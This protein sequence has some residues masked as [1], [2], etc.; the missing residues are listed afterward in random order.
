MVSGEYSRINLYSL[1]NRKGAKHSDDNCTNR[2]QES[3]GQ[4]MV[5]QIWAE[6]AQ[7][8]PQKDLSILVMNS[9]I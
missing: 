1:Q 6:T 3:I 9:I 5:L 8:I 7:K 2:S 4:A